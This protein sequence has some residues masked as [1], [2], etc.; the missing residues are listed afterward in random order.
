MGNFRA[1]RGV[2][3]KTFLIFYFKILINYAKLK[4]LGL[5]HHSDSDNEDHH[6]HGHSSNEDAKLKYDHIWKMTVTM[7]S[8]YNLKI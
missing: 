1:E 8:K 2:N 7:A 5:H 4:S 6:N 3:P